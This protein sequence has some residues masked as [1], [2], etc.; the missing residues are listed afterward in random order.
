[1]LDGVSMISVTTPTQFM[2]RELH[3][4]EPKKLFVISD[5]EDPLLTSGSHAT[6]FYDAIAIF[7]I[8]IIIFNADPLVGDA[9]ISSFATVSAAEYG[10]LHIS[11]VE[12]YR[13]IT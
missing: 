8:I 6:S 7:I 1:M 4:E 2:H 12:V 11:S 3:Q 10:E 9:K 5:I 13:R